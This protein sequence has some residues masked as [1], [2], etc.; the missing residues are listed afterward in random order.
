MKWS[1]R[2]GRIAGIA[3]YVH[4]TFLLLL[5]WVAISEYQS[6][7]DAAAAARGVI[8]VLAVFATVVLHELGHALSARRYGIRTRDITLLPIGGVARLE[9]MPKEPKQELIVALAGPAVNVV[10]AGILYLWLRVTGGVPPSVDSASL[11][12][13]FLERTFA[14]RLL[15][16]NLW[17]VLFNLIPAFPMDG[18]RVLRALLA[19][20]SRNY[21]RA[22]ETAARVGR[23]FALVFGVLGLFVVGNPFLVFIALF[24]WLGAAGEAAAAQTE[25]VLDG[26]PIQALMITDVRT[27]S[28]GDPLSRVVDLI[29]DG[30][31][32]DFPVLGRGG[33]VEGMLT[34][35]AMLKAL[36]ERGEAAR[37]DDVMARDFVQASPRDSAEDALTR[38]K[39][40][41]CHSMPVI[42]DGQLLGVLTMD[43]VGEY[44][45]VQAALRGT[46]TAFVP[47]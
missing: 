18:G 43:N 39:N 46:K 7:R 24:V 33:T 17:L 13:A 25:A 38:L 30:F 1:W 26:V 29:L 41:G 19:M 44:V 31:Q 34:R 47:A 42:E 20:R 28:P 3:L 35:A 22:T 4:A 27:L 21:T 23:F 37:V 10:I 14:A 9:R 2:L 45:M 16:V 8:F 15:A 32:Q 5:A 40:C 12:G 6:S 36:A 11:G